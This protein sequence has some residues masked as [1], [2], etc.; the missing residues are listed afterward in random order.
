MQPDAFAEDMPFGA[1][2]RMVVNGRE[3]FSFSTVWNDLPVDEK[4]KLVNPLDGRYWATRP[5]EAD[6]AIA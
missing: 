5:I 4:R 6:K 1:A 3:Y 2:R